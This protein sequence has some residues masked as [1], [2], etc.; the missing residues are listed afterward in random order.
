MA[1]QHSTHPDPLHH[2]LRILHTD[3]RLVKVVSHFIQLPLL[4]PSVEY[5][6]HT[7]GFHPLHALHTATAQ[8]VL[9][10]L[11]LTCIV[12]SPTATLLLD[13]TSLSHLFL[14]TLHH[15]HNHCS[16]HSP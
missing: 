10:N 11:A 1:K 16:Q 2:T 6:A 3:L 14:H 4:L 15:L 8:V 7:L 5:P 9:A 13:F 12:Q